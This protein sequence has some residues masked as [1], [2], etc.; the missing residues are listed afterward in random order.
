MRTA[1]LDRLARKLIK[2]A[3]AGDALAITLVM[4]TAMGP[5]NRDPLVQY[6][7]DNRRP[8]ELRELAAVLSNELQRC[9]S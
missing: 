3:L 7:N 5:L 8:L 4:A 6:A 2:R 9:G 1:N